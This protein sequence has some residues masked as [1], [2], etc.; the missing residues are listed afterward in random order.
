MASLE[1]FDLCIGESLERLQSAVAEVQEQK[2]EEKDSKAIVAKI[3]S[4][5]LEIWKAREIFYESMP[6]VKRDFK[7]ENEEDERRYEELNAI[8][9]KAYE[10]EKNGDFGKATQVYDKLL[11]VSKYGFFKLTA[12]AGIYRCGVEAIQTK[13]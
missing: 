7:R 6:Q 13:G 10:F 8:L 4:A 12:Q 9:N 5:I 3:A 1:H 11:Q 2:S